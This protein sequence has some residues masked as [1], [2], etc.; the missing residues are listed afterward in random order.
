VRLKSAF[1]ERRTI[2]G[3]LLFAFGAFGPQ[4]AE[5]F[6]GEGL[7]LRWAG[8]V[9][10]AAGAIVTLSA[11]LEF[12]PSKGSV[13]DKWDQNLVNATLTKAPAQATI[14]ILQTSFPNAA[15]LLPQLRELLLSRDKRFKI[16][17]ALANPFTAEGKA[18]I[19]ARVR[20]RKQGPEEHRSE[21]LDHIR[22]FEKLKQD[23]DADW[24]GS[25]DNA[26]LNLEIKLYDHLPFGPQFH[27]GDD[28]FVGFFVSNESSI[29]APMVSFRK[30]GGR[31]W[32]VFHDDFEA[33]WRSAAPH[34]TPEELSKARS[35]HIK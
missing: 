4:L 23:V 9:V 29:V 35:S 30:G 11:F 34:S 15:E 6:T 12:S 17:L 24:A 27:I 33:V 2:V 20:L 31:G 21:I 1:K 7:Q 16:R 10:A 32:Q 18:I 22:Q 25:R 28:I 8:I 3:G 13:Y 5:V 26:K 19:A 14:N